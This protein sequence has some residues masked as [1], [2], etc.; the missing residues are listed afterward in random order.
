L[1]TSPFPVARISLAID[2][3]LTK[4]TNETLAGLRLLVAYRQDLVA[5]EARVIAR[6]RES[7]VRLFPSLERR[8]NWTSPGSLILVARYQTP[9]PQHHWRRNRFPA[10]SAGG[11]YVGRRLGDAR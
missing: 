9:Q 3:G 7:L 1:R 10:A 8:P 2:V 6:V 5:D 4:P 11:H